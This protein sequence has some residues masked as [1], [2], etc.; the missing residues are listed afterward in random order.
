MT[1]RM[2]KV[3]VHYDEIALKGKK[4]KF[5]EERLVANLNDFLRNDGIPMRARKSW[6]RIFIE[7]LQED[8][9]MSAHE[10]QLRSR[11]RLIPGISN[12]GFALSVPKDYESL[13]S[14]APALAERAAGG[15]FRVTARR[16]DKSFPKRSQE[17]EREYGAAMLRTGQPLKVS[18]KHFDSEAH[19]EVLD[20]EIIAYLK[21]RG[22]G[23]LAVGSSGRIVSLISA[24]FDSPVASFMLMKRGARI[25]PLHFHSAPVTSDEP[26]AAVHD[27]CATLSSI[28]GRLTLALVPVIGIQQHLEEH[29]PEK[30]RI[31]LLRR[32]FMRLSCRYAQD[33]GALALATG[34]SLGQVA[35]QTLENMR[36]I[37][38][39]AFLPVMRPL[40]GLNKTEIIDIARGIGTAEIS[41]RPCEDTC[42]LFVPK[43]PE[44]KAK[45]RE[46]LTAE[47]KLDLS[48]ME[49]EA[50]AGLETV[51]FAWGSEFEDSEQA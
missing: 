17:I 19:I 46:V 13:L 51:H 2:T 45:M 25:L 50:M 9:D 32:S 28:Q 30:L 31:V 21:E 15:T 18:L 36:A 8:T 34:E 1:A 3:V 16:T 20:R 49:D 14:T 44:T 37:D 40:C 35:S 42:A 6:G 47:E 12:Y 23:G 7:P 33:S 27:L 38:D 22:I 4:R 43:S 48:R 26:I 41:A 29:A 5:F 24:G 11:L 39:A 10:E